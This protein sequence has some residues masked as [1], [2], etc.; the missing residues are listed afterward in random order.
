MK[1]EWWV[2]FL[3]FFIILWLGR[4]DVFG[5]V[6]ML[7]FDWCRCFFL[8]LYCIALCRVIIRIFESVI[9]I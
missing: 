6:L 1:I 2:D 3:L 9:I 7:S 8:M 5:Y 4:V